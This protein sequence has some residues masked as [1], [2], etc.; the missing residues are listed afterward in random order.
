MRRFA[1]VFFT[2]ALVALFSTAALAAGVIS[3]NVTGEGGTSGDA[4]EAAY[5]NGQFEC[6]QYFDGFATGYQVI[7]LMQYPGFW[8]AELNVS[9][10]VP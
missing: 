1:K 7:S 10:Y 8:W 4:I 9:C 6:E 5:A 3:I 2:T